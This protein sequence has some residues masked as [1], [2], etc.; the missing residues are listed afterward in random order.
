VGA[1]E[2]AR[3]MS[4]GWPPVLERGVA[5]LAHAG[6]GRSG[7]VAVF[8]P[9]TGGGLVAVIDGLGHGDPAADAA[10]AASAILQAHADLPPQDLLER[11]HDELRRT[12]GAVMTLAWFDLDE[13]SLRW[14]GV[15]NVEARLVREGDDL[16]SRF[17]SPVVLGGVV[18]YNLPQVRVGTV[19][20]A[21][22]DAVALATDGVA[23]DYSVSLE[24]GVAAQA[25]ADR[26]LERHGKGTDDALAVVVRYLGAPGS[27]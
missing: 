24:S 23:A 14:T 18:G 21:P 25:L 16:G 13:G 7:D 27:R 10:E 26:I 3:G 20:L 5:G 6:E 17:A 12:R 4:G 9:F 11:C 22:G 8:A 15:G 1:V 19:P 2:F